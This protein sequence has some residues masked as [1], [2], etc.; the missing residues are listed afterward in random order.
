MWSPGSM[1]EEIVLGCPDLTWKHIFG[2][3]NR[4]GRKGMITTS[5]KRCS[6]YGT[7]QTETTRHRSLAMFERVHVN[8]VYVYTRPDEGR[9]TIMKSQKAKEVE[10][11]ILRQDVVA[12]LGTAASNSKSAR[13]ARPT[14][15]DLH[16]RIT[17]RA[18]ELYVQR[19]CREGRAVEDWLDAEREI[20][21][22]EFPG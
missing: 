4:V 14:F 6:L 11:R 7:F 8:G 3:M 12:Q 13:H 20:V 9:G 5:P 17:T 2:V 1:L 18:Y 10:V 16:A 15:D 22:R 19:G 21:S